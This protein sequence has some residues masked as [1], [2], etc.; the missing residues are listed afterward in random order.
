MTMP[1]LPSACAADEE[2]DSDAAGDEQPKESRN[3][4]DRSM[5]TSTPVRR[6]ARLR[7]EL[8]VMG[9]R[10]ST[11]FS[12]C[13]SWR[14]D[15]CLETQNEQSARASAHRASFSS[16]AATQTRRR[17]G[18]RQPLCG[19]GVTS[20][21]KVTLK[22]AVWSARS[23][24]SRPAPG[25]FTKTAMLRIP[26]SIALRAASSAASW[27]ANGVDLRE[28]LKPRE[29]ADDHAT[30]FPFTSVIVTTVLLNV[31]WIW[32]IPVEMFFLTFFFAGFLLVGAAETGPPLVLPAVDMAQISF[33]N[34]SNRSCE[35]RRPERRRAW[36]PPTHQTRASACARRG[37]RGPY[38]DLCGYAR[39]CA[40]AGR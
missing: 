1:A 10:F 24:L 34:V 38:A 36:D 9:R 28:P 13:E 6:P 31:D 21:I 39:W 20:R 19:T 8:L 22:P 3:V 11:A 18:G 16:R 33:K 7:G 17:L 23:A 29:P 5:P 30:E 4:E 27:A 37:K 15:P 25:P 26:C 2:V 32:A 14:P 35:G 12:T 40:C